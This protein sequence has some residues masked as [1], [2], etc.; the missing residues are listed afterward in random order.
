MNVQI[1]ILS[2]THKTWYLNVIYA[3]LNLFDD[4]STR[5]CG[6][7][8]YKVSIVP[9]MFGKVDVELPCHL[10][11]TLQSDASYTNSIIEFQF[12]DIYII[13]QLKFDAKPSVWSEYYDQTVARSSGSPESNGDEDI[14]NPYLYIVQVSK[15]AS[16]WSTVI[17]HS[18]CK[19]YFTQ[20]LYFPRHAAK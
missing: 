17:D 2:Q 7:S 19:C 5:L 10:E 11:F 13:N 9:E 20:Q 16:D 1:R 15:D 3:G 6:S 8:N 18:I 14:K 4:P 12:D